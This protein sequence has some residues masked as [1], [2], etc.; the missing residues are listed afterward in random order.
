MFLNC[1]YRTTYSDTFT[2]WYVQ[3][4]NEA[5]QLLLKSATESQK[6]ENQGFQATLVKKD[7]SFHLQKSSLQLS[8]SAVYYCTMRDTVRGATGVLGTNLES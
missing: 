4:L 6:I 7:N 2:L 5:P 3:Y 1:T 8:D